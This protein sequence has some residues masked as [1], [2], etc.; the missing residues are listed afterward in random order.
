MTP[1]LQQAKTQ[2]RA[3]AR[4]LLAAMTPAE[5]AEASRAVCERLTAWP[6]FAQARAVLA[7][8]PTAEEVDLRE[9]LNFHLRKGGV[10]CLPRL[11]WGGR[12]MV[13]AAIQ[14]L[15][16]VKTGPRGIGEPPEGAPHL[17]LADIDVVLV[18]GLAFDEAG[19]RLGRGAGFYDRFLASST[20]RAVTCAP[21]FDRQVWPSI[22]AE[23]HDIPVQHLIT[24]SRLLAAA[25]SPR[26]NA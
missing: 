6:P 24:E 14:D 13:P 9:A 26:H 19:N 1:D 18:P 2:A 21:A 16:E 5:R 15:D 23:A 8:L 7:Y 20:L 11:D 3:R 17:A 4:A 12:G 10:L 25:R 22:P